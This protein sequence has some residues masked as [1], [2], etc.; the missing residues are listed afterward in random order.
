MGLDLAKA[1]GVS[2]VVLH[3]DS[4]VFIGHINT[5][6]EA[7]GERMKKYLDLIR[8]WTSQTFKVKFL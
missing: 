3:K 7:K 1:T 8:R 6:Y 5:D 2:L 4:Q